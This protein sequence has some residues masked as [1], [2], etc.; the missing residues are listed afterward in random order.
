MVYNFLIYNNIM[1]QFQVLCAGVGRKSRKLWILQK[2]TKTN[3]SEVVFRQQELS[4]INPS[5]N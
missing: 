1:K 5:I 4:T 2:D 3:Q